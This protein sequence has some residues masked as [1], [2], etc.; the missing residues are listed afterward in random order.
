MPSDPLQIRAGDLT[1]A[2][3]GSTDQRGRVLQSAERYVHL[4]WKQKSNEGWTAF[5]VD[6]VGH[7]SILTLSP[8]APIRR[9]ITWADLREHPPKDWDGAN[10]YRVKW[11][12]M[13]VDA[14]AHGRPLA[15]WCGPLA[16]G[17]AESV[18]IEVPQGHV[19]AEC[20]ED[21]S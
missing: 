2:H 18:V 17:R 14:E 5:S 4:K 10:V 13:K 3:I 8:P 16:I 7:D 6:I 12:I 1:A 20:G 19:L 11:P 21:A 9:R 15:D